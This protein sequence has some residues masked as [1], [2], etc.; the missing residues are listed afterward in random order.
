MI[1]FY[2]HGPF[3]HGS[4]SLLQTPGWTHMK[5]KLYWLVPSP[6]VRFTL[7]TVAQHLQIEPAIEKFT[8]KTEIILEAKASECRV[9]CGGVQYTGVVKMNFDAGVIPLKIQLRNLK[10]AILCQLRI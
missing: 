8:K 2:L 5:N 7:V 9:F 4:G 3:P 6:P 1:S 10:K